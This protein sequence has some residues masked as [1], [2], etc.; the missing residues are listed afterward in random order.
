M[1]TGMI[2]PL[3]NLR[4]T[5]IFYFSISWIIRTLIKTQSQCFY[6]V[7]QTLF[8]ISIS[9]ENQMGLYTEKAHHHH[10]HQNR[11]LQLNHSQSV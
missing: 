2:Y 6:L 5:R 9:A 10:R 1:C 3:L 7:L 11:S 4:I 8:H